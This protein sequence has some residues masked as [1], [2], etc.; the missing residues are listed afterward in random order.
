MVKIATVSSFVVNLASLFVLLVLL[1]Q[2]AT[3]F[4][5]FVKFVNYRVQ[6]VYGYSTYLII[7]LKKYIHD[8][9]RRY[10]ETWVS[11]CTILLTRQGRIRII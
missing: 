9:I 2:I 7:P 4:L 6:Y 5:Y 11:V 8:G 3:K 10:Y 1:D